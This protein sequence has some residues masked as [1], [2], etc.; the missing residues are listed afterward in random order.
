[1]YKLFLVF[2][3]LFSN[4]IF[5]D[6]NSAEIISTEPTETSIT[7]KMTSTNT[8]ISEWFVGVAES[9][10][11]YIAGKKL[12]DKTNTSRLRLEEL[13]SAK[14]GQKPTNDFSVSVVLR[15]PNVEEYWQVKFTSYDE[16]E[17]RRRNQTGYLQ[18]TRREES[19]AASIGL[20]RKLGNVR[21]AFQPRIQ[22]QNPIAVSHSLSFDSDA[23]M[24]TYTISPKIDFYAAADKGTGVYWELNF[25]TKINEFQTLNFVNNADYISQT[26]L[27]SV[28]NG[29][30]ISED[31]NDDSAISYGLNFFSNNLTNYHL[32]GYS[33]YFNWHQELKKNILDY[34][35]TPHLDFF[36]EIDFVGQVGISMNIGL[37]F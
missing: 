18:Q 9:I 13:V 11:L 24:G 14:E 10:D 15:L 2:I 22:L 23:D 1:L 37:S 20:F 3:L 28:T 30:F 12:T 29:F 32:E 7:E 27:N 35:I 4:C 19:Y 33:L 26:H 31:I 25:K 8:A 5:A 6:E 21:T 16:Q 17:E 34:S 36:R